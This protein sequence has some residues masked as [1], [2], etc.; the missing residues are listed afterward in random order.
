MKSDTTP[1]NVRSSTG[2]NNANF[3]YAGFS[4]DPTNIL[5]EVGAFAASPGPYGTFDQ[6][7]NLCQWTEAVVTPNFS[8]ALRGGN[9]CYG[10]SYMESNCRFSYQPSLTGNVFGF[11]V[12]SVPEPGSITLLVGAAIIGL[13][14]WRRRI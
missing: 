10:S 6:G 12:A 3:A 8:R 5:T 11:R 9:W 7:G 1:S 14:W 13:L 2:A 4:S